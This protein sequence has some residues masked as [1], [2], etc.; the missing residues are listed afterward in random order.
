ALAG[1]GL[2]LGVGGALNAG[3]TALT[4]PSVR[5][6]AAD[7]LSA[8]PKLQAVSAATGAGAASGTREAGGGE[9]AQVF[10]GLAGGL[11]PAAVTAGTPMAFRGAL[12]GGEAN[13]RN[14]EAAID[15]FAAL[16]ATP[17]V[18]QG[19]GAWSR[20]GAENLLGAFPTS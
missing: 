8:Q 16:G 9:L 12:R 7:F 19:T 2:T 17:T 11:S 1:T 6:A 15:D 14:L 10:A 5:T 13:R 20:Q 18:G 3:R 4:A